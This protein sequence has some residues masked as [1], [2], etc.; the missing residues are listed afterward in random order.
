MRARLKHSFKELVEANQMYRE[1]WPRTKSNTKKA[2]TGLLPL[3][4][5]PTTFLADPTHQKI[6]GKHLYALAK[7][8]KKAS[9]VNKVRALR[10]KDYWGAYLKQVRDRNFETKGDNIMRLSKAPLEHCFNNLEFCSKTW[11][12]KL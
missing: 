12:Y 6:D 10:L 1:D 3:A 5:K 4:I 11:C 2:D 9:K 8:V 7:L